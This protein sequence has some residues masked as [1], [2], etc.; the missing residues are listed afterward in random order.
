MGWLLPA[1][2]QDLFLIQYG[3]RRKL[4]ERK[5]RSQNL[6]MLDFLED[7]ARKQP[8]TNFLI[9]GKEKLTYQETLNEMNKERIPRIIFVVNGSS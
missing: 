7:W 6:T 5:A 3:I 2:K 9:Q 4:L 8:N 1:L